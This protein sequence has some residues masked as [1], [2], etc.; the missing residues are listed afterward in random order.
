[1]A[2]ISEQNDDMVALVDR[3]NDACITVYE[4]DKLEFVVGLMENNERLFQVSVMLNQLTQCTLAELSTLLIHLTR[5]LR[6]YGPNDPAPTL[7][8]TALQGLIASE[9]SDRRGI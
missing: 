1:M 9:G 7:V 8:L 5:V 3:L 2:L 4:N 6:S